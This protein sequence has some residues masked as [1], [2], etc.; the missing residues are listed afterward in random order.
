MSEKT[1]YESNVEDLKKQF[2]D[3]EKEKE[4]KS[5]KQKREEIL[6]RIYVPRKSKEIFRILPPKR[7]NFYNVA[8]FHNIQINTS[9]G[10]KRWAKIYCPRHNNPK[11]PKLDS[12]GKPILQENG[13]P[14]MLPESCPLCEKHDKI[15]ATQNDSVKYKKR[16]DLNDEEKKIFDENKEKF[17]LAKQYEAIKFYIIKGIDRWKMQ[18]GPKFWRFKDSFTN[19][20]VMDK[21]K[22]VL[23]EYID[24]H[25]KDFMSPTHGCDL[26]IIMGDAKT[27]A[28]RPYKD[29]SAITARGPLPLHDESYV[30]E[31][32][33]KNELIWRDAF[34]PKKAPNITP[35][36]YLQ[37][38][39]KGNDPYYDEID[40]KWV[41][42]GNKDL[43]EKANTRDRDLDGVSGE[44]FKQA[45][46]LEETDSDYEINLSN[47]KEEDVGEFK[48]DSLDIKEEVKS[49]K[50]EAKSEKEEAKSEKEEVKTNVDEIDDDDYNDLP[51]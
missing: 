17:M 50:E 13:E 21:L 2:E 46:D 42:P 6:E 44:N 5:A 25:K 11:T 29:V 20:G 26:S 35:H 16:E 41:F 14:I 10:N 39:A 18:D 8:Y 19:R 40:K 22:P 23:E 28:G 12:K 24:V 7:G 51:F 31:S 38:L 37:M 9:G 47:I 15:I 4:Q 36:Q 48:D 27:P 45:S 49:E 33:L 1:N 32:W 30:A 34:K 3:Y 43:E